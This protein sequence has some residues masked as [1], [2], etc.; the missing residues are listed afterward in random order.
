MTYKLYD[1]LGIDKNASS[2][3]IKKAYKKLAI[4]HHPDKGGNQEKFKEI[5][6]AYHVLSD[7]DKRRNYDQLG[8][9]MFNEGND[10]GVNPFEGMNPHDLF[11]NL[12]GGFGFEFP[13]MHGIHGMQE[14]HVKRNDQLHNL[15][16]SFNDAFTGFKKTIKINLVKV[17]LSCKAECVQCQ[18]KGQINEIRRMGPFTQMITQ[19]CNVCQG[20]GQMKKGNNSCNECGGKCM[21]NKEY[22]LDLEIPRGVNNGFEQRFKGY[23]EQKQNKKE[24]SGDLIFRV[25]IVDDPIFKRRGQDLIYN[26]TITFKESIIGKKINVSYFG[27]MLEI[28]LQKYT[29]IQPNKEYILKG[30]GMPLDNQGSSFGNLILIFNIKYPS[31]SNNINNQSIE[32]IEKILSTLGIQ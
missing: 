3:E 7:E 12:F 20:T 32:D 4:Q 22:K 29:V 19:A 18:G 15:S 17:C 10:G 8:D 25:N 26:E 23:G 30:K 28:D 9:E 14:R 24:I 2:D 11:S 1:I 27:E 13:G 5:S 16:I 21:I 6:N 31:I